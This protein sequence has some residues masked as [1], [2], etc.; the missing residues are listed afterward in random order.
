MLSLDD[1]EEEDD[2]DVSD[3]RDEFESEC[4]TALRVE[5][6]GIEYLCLRTAT[7]GEAGGVSS[8]W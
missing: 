1:A 5:K 2:D 6:L 4:E 3:E 8:L 7:P